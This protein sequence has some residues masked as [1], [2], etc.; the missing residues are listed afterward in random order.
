[1][2]IGGYCEATA[3][4]ISNSVT[5]SVTVWD[6]LRT[7][8]IL[9]LHEGFPFFRRRD[10]SNMIYQARCMFLDLRLQASTRVNQRKA[11]RISHGRHTDHPDSI[12]NPSR[13]ENYC[14]LDRLT[15]TLIP[16]KDGQRSAGLAHPDG[17]AEHETRGGLKGVVDLRRRGK[18]ASCSQAV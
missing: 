2:T 12:L 8:P 14:R 10:H 7:Y 5:S 13:G 17:I 18:Q 9:E 16:C 3:Q 6:Q 15:S 11:P 4:V 1:M